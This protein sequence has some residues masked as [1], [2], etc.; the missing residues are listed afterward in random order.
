MLRLASSDGGDHGD[1][2]FA[3]DGCTHIVVATSSEKVNM[4][5][6]LAKA[7]KDSPE[8]KALDD[9]RDRPADQR[10]VR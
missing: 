10:L 9:V 1:G 7:F 5:D 2:D 4:L 6:A 3:D 8:M